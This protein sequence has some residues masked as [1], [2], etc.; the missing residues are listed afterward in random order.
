MVC[1]RCRI[2]GAAGMTRVEPRNANVWRITCG[3][4][5][6]IWRRGRDLNPGWACTHNS[7]QVRTASGCGRSPTS[8]QDQKRSPMQRICPWT[9]TFVHRH[10]CQIAVKGTNRRTSAAQSS[11]AITATTE[12]RQLAIQGSLG[13]ASRIR[14]VRACS[15]LSSS[16]QVVITT[17]PSKYSVSLTLASNV[18]W[19][20]SFPGPH[21]Q[22]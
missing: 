7:F 13:K 6:G 9:S 22:T 2:A 12:A 15:R 8:T 5:R 19:T 10:C 16:C 20:S 3:F 18:S 14:K 17:W 4:A 21:T 11:L 1:R